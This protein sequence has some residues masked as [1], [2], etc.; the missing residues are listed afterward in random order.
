MRVHLCK[1]PDLG[2]VDIFSITEGNNLI[3]GEDEVKAVLRNLTLLQDT[4]IFRNLPKYKKNEHIS[5]L[6]FR[7]LILMQQP[8]MNRQVSVLQK[9]KTKFDQH[10]F[11][12]SSI[13][14]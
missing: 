4:T 9:T 12:F 13:T 3:E 11:Y 6:P 14:I 2:Q 8:T 5:Q 7:T 10:I 1:C